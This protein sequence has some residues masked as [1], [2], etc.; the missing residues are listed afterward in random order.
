MV[1]QTNDLTKGWTGTQGGKEAPSDVY[2]WT[3]TY[4]TASG[5]KKAAKGT[6]V[7]IR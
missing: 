6:V 4:T 7:L 5:Q 2:A 1:F 3:C